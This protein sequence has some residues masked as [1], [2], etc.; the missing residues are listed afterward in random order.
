[1]VEGYIHCSSFGLR[2]DAHYE[3]C[4]LVGLEG[5]GHQQVVARWEGETLR[6]LTCVD[7]GVASCLRTV[8]AEEILVCVVLVIR[9]LERKQT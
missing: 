2:E 5:G 7:V 4:L 8:E 3:V 6:H 9:R 1:M